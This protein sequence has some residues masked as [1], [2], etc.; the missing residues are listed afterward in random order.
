MKKYW[1]F[2]LVLFG[3]QWKSLQGQNCEELLEQFDTTPR[4]EYKL[5]QTVA[6]KA[7]SVCM[8]ERG[9]SDSLYIE[10]LFDLGLAFEKMEHWATADSFYTASLQLAKQNLPADHW[11]FDDLY[12]SLGVV[13]ANLMRYDSAIV[14]YDCSLAF[15]FKNRGRNSGYWTTYGNKGDIYWRQGEYDKAL[16]YFLEG[17]RLMDSLHLQKEKIYPNMH[18]Y[19]GGLLRTLGKPEEGLPY[20][21]KA[22]ELYE[23]LYG[24]EHPQYTYSLGHLA[25]NYRASGKVFQAIK[26]MEEAIDI[27]ER[28]GRGNHPRHASMLHSLAL[29]LNETGQY[30]KALELQLKALEIRQKSQ[31]DETLYSTLIGGIGNTYQR[32]GQYDKALEYQWRAFKIAEKTIGRNH[33]DFIPRLY[34]L[35]GVYLNLGQVEKASSLYEEAL[36]R[37][38]TVYGKQHYFYAFRLSELAHCFDMKNDFE[39]AFDYYQRAYRHSLSYSDTLTL[40]HSNKLNNLMVAYIN[41]KQYDKA[42]PY[43]QSLIDLT[44]KVM[45]EEDPQYG[46]RLNNLGILFHH[47]NKFDEAKKYFSESLENARRFLGPDHP[48]YGYSFANAAALYETLRQPQKA[49]DLYQE[50]NASYLAQAR[51]TYGALSEFEKNAFFEALRKRF[52]QVQSFAWRH[53]QDIPEVAGVLYDNALVL[54]GQLLIGVKGVFETARRSKNPELASAYQDWLNARQVLAHLYTLPASKRFASTDS[55]E[56]VANEL[57]RDLAR[58]SVFFEKSIRP[59]QWQDLSTVLDTADASVEFIHFRYR[60][61]GPTD[62]ILYCA[63]VYRPGFVQPKLV[64]LFEEKQLSQLF[65]QKFRRPRDFVHFMY[66]AE[67]YRLVWQ[68]LETLLADAQTVYYSPSGL[69]HRIS[70][71]AI[72]TSDGTV[73]ADR[74]RLDYVSSTRNILFRQEDAKP[75]TFSTALLYGG[76]DYNT[77]TVESPLSSNGATRQSVE[78][79]NYIL[80]SLPMDSTR[81]AWGRLDSSL[82]EV[83]RLERLLKSKYIFTMTLREKEGTEESFQAI[84]KQFPCPEILH[85]A[86]HGFFFPDPGKQT[87]S[88]TEGGREN[89]LYSDNPLL[90]SGLILSGADS[91]WVYGAVAPGREDGILTAFEISRQNLSGVKLVV[92]SAC[93]TGLGD[94]RGSEGVYGLQRAFKM[95]GAHYLLLTLWNIPDG[96]ETVEFM[97]TFYEKCLSGMPVKIAFHETQQAMKTKYPDPYFWA[98]FIL[99]D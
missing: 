50:A 28:M 65:D 97:T 62:S 88:A 91:A 15:D 24:K 82:V 73:L 72:P 76:L 35:A 81:S 55:L 74:Y 64:P 68:P 59:V 94:I 86:T 31:Q 47:L 40:S 79:D 33:P 46:I 89:L 2:I 56:Q 6:E 36:E 7:V 54:K 99:I 12:N 87:K 77:N 95:A 71:P 23:S 90:R 14:Y 44:P 75:F 4:Q 49:F 38:E 84:S 41:L 96:K 18:I 30:H 98:G 58:A 80:R 67:L 13:S 1:L 5:L 26:V 42:L 83:N 92:L 63:L 11:L 53:Q 66:S 17:I 34:L 48:D 60:N 19:V 20:N 21:L 22:L 70:F 27:S 32:L 78:T 52:E 93:Q 43:A 8:T 45:S 85:I 9:T 10:A 37:T 29:L 51:L 69:L 57:E 16:A 25:E 39:H 61:D 3:V